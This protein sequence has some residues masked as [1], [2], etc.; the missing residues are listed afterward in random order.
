M[1]KI[2]D[3]ITHTALLERELDVPDAKNLKGKVHFK[4][5]GKIAKIKGKDVSKNSG[6]KS[7]HIT[8]DSS[9]T[10]DLTKE[11]AELFSEYE[12]LK[13]TK[14]KVDKKLAEFELNNK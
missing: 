14:L 3:L 9:S 5:E 7:A 4:F 12:Q 13:I 6:V 10:G 11:E 2:N 8:S 1:S